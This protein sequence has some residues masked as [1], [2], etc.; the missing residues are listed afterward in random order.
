MTDQTRSIA[1]L[2]VQQLAAGYGPLTICH[3]INFT[4]PERTVLAVIGPN[5]AGKT[6]LIRAVSGLIPS[7]GRVYIGEH[8]E[9]S[10]TAAHY[11]AQ[12][13]LVTVPDDRAIFPDFTIED[14]L[15][16]GA[17]LSGGKWN[18]PDVLV[19][20]FDRFPA[21]AKRQHTA[22]G[23]LSGGEQQ[24]LAIGKALAAK[25]RVLLLDEPSQGLSPSVL[26]DLGPSLMTLRKENLA[27][28]IAEQ[29]LNLVRDL[30]DTY[31]VIVDGRVVESGDTSDLDSEKIARKFLS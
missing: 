1:A 12:K 20:L 7:A 10:G 21:L 19:E 2:T 6:T 25:P 30:A 14:N 31:L 29:N 9:I 15:R 16:L 4:L 24:M 28:V 27:I 5:G 22:A 11:R 3:D 8:Q 13:G 26:A 23:L 17:S 18:T